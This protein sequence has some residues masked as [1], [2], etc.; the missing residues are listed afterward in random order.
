M[1]VL[2]VGSWVSPA[3]ENPLY[4]AFKDLNYNVDSFKWGPL[5]G[6]TP[7]SNI[8]NDKSSFL[9]SLTSRAQ[10]KYICGPA[11]RKIN[12]E[13]LN[14]VSDCKPDLIFLYRATHIWAKSIKKVKEKG[15]KVMVYNNDDPFTDKL[16]S[17][18]YKNYF[19]TLPLA[20]WIFSYRDKN[21]QDYKK[22]GYE[23]VSLL[24]SSYTN[25]INFPLDKSPKEYDLIFIGHFEN[26]GRDEFLFELMQK[27]KLKIGLWG[28]DW[29][30][31]QHFNYFE[32]YLGKSITGLYGASYNET[33]NNAKASLVFFS[34]VNN[35]NYTRRV[36]E[37]PA[38][39][40]TMICEHTEEMT[41]LFEDGKE[42]LLFKDISEL[43]KIAQKL[44]SNTNAFD[45][46]GLAG[47]QRLLKDGHEIKDR[48]REI[49]EK[50][51]SL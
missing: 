34:K 38:T 36:F 10:N 30:K 5:L 51:K 33:I 13:F 27:T 21:I 31:S 43:L 18:V 29:E 12:R 19:Q 28:L 44:E 9:S 42:V 37:I 16:P 39:K 1:K 47:H 32:K 40:T 41:K 11:I 6:F 24:R 48:V 46:I 26:D 20:D 25:E 2:I 23:N 4:N 35:D 3:Y 7:L 14:K 17:Y 8:Y 45:E 15:I 49:V 22:L 50:A